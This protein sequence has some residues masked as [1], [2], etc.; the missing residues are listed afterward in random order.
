MNIDQIADYA[1]RI[2]QQVKEFNESL[3]E[4]VKSAFT[5]KLEEL[6]KQHA[7]FDDLGIPDEAE[8]PELQPSSGSTPPKKGKGRGK[9]IIQFV[10]NLYVHQLNQTNNNIGDVNNAIQAE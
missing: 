8:P 7:A 10:E 3:P 9:H 4:Q 2:N 1:G 6:T 5:V